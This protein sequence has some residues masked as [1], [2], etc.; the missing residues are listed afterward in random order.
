MLDALVVIL[1][2][3]LILVSAQEETHG[4]DSVKSRCLHHY[5]LCVG[6][7]VFNLGHE[8]PARIF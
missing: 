1:L 8:S 3:S 4:K 6:C 2:I 7:R 5:R